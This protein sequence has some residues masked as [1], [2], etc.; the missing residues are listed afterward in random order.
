[1]KERANIDIGRD[2]HYLLHEAAKGNAKCAFLAGLAFEELGYRPFFVQA[3]FRRAADLG[4]PIAQRWLGI[5]GLC[6]Q[7]QTENCTFSDVS[8]Y[9]D[10]DAALSWL[11]KAAAGKDKISSLILAKCKMLGI[12][13]DVDEIG[14]E[15]E[16]KRVVPLLNDN[17]VTAVALLFEYIRLENT[18][19]VLNNFRYLRDTPLCELAS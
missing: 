1:M 14:G 15:M 8:Y 11:K 3:Q 7:L 6:H 18:H 2:I 10:Y 16:V 9:Q 4:Y 17:D 19:S 5:L 12:G 13:M